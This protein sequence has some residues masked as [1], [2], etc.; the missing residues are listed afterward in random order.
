M[1]VTGLGHT[2]QHIFHAVT[3]N[4]LIGFLRTDRLNMRLEEVDSAARER[5]KRVVYAVIYGVGKLILLH[6]Q[7]VCVACMP[8][9]KNDLQRC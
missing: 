5:T 4:K 9:E 8:Q 1:A 2:A 7:Y 6:D 3:C